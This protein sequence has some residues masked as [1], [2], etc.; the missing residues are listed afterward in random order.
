M[1]GFDGLSSGVAA[2]VFP[3]LLSREEQEEWQISQGLQG[4][5]HSVL[6]RH[7]VISFRSCYLFAHWI[8]R[9][10]F[11]DAVLRSAFLVPLAKIFGLGRFG[12]VSLLLFFVLHGVSVYDSFLFGLLLFAVS[13]WSWP[14]VGN[15]V[16]SV[17]SRCLF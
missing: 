2:G 14:K 11:L 10:T 7:Q 16:P 4:I 15:F 12:C 3:L 13:I 5:R 1:K 17:M 8:V 6:L 9:F